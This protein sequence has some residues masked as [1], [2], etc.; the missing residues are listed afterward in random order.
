MQHTD[1]PAAMKIA[2][3]QGIY[4][5]GQASNMHTFGPNAQLTA[6]IDNWGPYYVSRVKAVMDGTWSSGDTWDGIGAGMVGISDFSDKIPADVRKLAG[7]ARDALAAGKLHAF[8]GPINKQDGSA[9][10]VAGETANDGD[11]A[12]MN[13]YVE[14]VEGS[15]PQ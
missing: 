15:L 7:D 12:G 6:I 9:W 2:E 1:S 10:L 5:F 11:L 4:A 8:T 13:F 14:G 3:D